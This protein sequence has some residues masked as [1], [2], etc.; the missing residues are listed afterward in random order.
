[1]H[2]SKIG[3]VGLQISA[4]QA[5]SFWEKVEKIEG[6]CWLWRGAIRSDGYGQLNVPLVGEVWSSGKQKCKAVVAHRAAWFLIHGK[7]PDEFMLDGSIVRLL[8]GC[9]VRNCVNVVD[10]VKHVHQGTPAENSAEMV[11]RGRAPSGAEHYAQREPWRLSRG[12]SVGTAKLTEEQVAI[13]KGEVLIAPRSAVTGLVR[14]GVAARLAEHFGVS[15]TTVHDIV[16]GR[17]WWAH[18]EAAKIERSIL[19]DRICK[20]PGHAK[21]DKEKALEVRRLSAQGMTGIQLTEKFGLSRTAIYAIINGLTW[22]DAFGPAPFDPEQSLREVKS[23]SGEA[24]YKAKLTAE[25]VT[26]LRARA[27]AGEPWPTLVAE[28]TNKFGVL[29]LAIYDVLNGKT[30]RFEKAPLPR[31]PDERIRLTD[32]QVAEIKASY[33]AKSQTG[34]QL[35]IMFKVPKST[36]Y[37]ILAGR[38]RA[39]VPFPKQE[40]N[41]V[42]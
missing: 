23:N 16:A 21:I 28:Y 37:T 26:E 41:D 10:Q 2:E 40:P 25:A 31:S 15:R 9:D 1:M 11:A 32:Q 7:W 12:N 39:D 27:I 42:E 34:E 20:R 36:I 18:V 6:G 35:A 29:P 33:A 22:P 30:W 4:R 24:H 5:T 38:S 14:E 8:H 3:V 19:P 17:G 13:I